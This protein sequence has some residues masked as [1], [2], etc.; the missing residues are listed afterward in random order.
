[1]FRNFGNHEFFEDFFQFLQ[2]NTINSEVLDYGCG[3]G[4]SLEKVINFHP[5]KITGIDIS[6]VS[7]ENGFLIK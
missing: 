3:V 2:T 4:V 5:K 1:M 6:E 7:I